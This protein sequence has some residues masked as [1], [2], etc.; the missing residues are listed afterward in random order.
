M[1]RMRETVGSL[2]LYFLLAGCLGVAGAIALLPFAARLQ[3]LLIAVLIVDLLFSA[4][5]I[6]CGVALRGLLARAPGVIKVVLWTSLGMHLAEAAAL[7]ALIRDPQLLISPALATLITL[8]LIINVNRLAKAS[9]RM[10]ETEKDLDHKQREWEEAEAE[11]QDRSRGWIVFVVL[12]GVLVLFLAAFAGYVLLNQKRERTPPGPRFESKATLTGHNSP[13]NCVAFSPDGTL[14]ASVGFEQ[15]KLWEVNTAKVKTTLEGHKGRV[16]SV[17]FSPGGGRLASGGEDKT[18][19]LWLLATGQLLTTLEGH[20][21]SVTAVA[22]GP[23]GNTLASA[24]VKEIKLWDVQTG[25]ERATLLGHP[26]LVNSLAFS[27]TNNAQQILASGGG[28]LGKPGEIKLW[29]TTASKETATLTGHREMVNSVAFGP[30]GNTLAS[31]SSHD[32]RLWDVQSGVKKVLATVSAGGNCVAFS[33]DGKTLASDGR[34]NTITL[35]EVQKIGR[36]SPTGLKER[37]SLEGH[38]GMV[39]FLAFSPNA[40]MLASGSEDTTIKLWSALE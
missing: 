30:D 8:Y 18:I 12:G 23:D 27:P 7:F 40:K 14:L 4:A 10:R 1:L 3:P 38:S 39:H 28:E 13:V 5:F 34:H 19:K 17:A 20:K 35:W 2:R 24:S 11:L 22:F 32:I 15:I 36:W 37:A 33:P 16:S 21:D 26:G 29:D 6:F 25:K 9:D 31:A